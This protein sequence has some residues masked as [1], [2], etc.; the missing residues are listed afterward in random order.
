V[1]CPSNRATLLA[2]KAIIEAALT[3]L[4][5][6]YDELLDDNSESYSFD[7]G[8]GRQSTKRRTLE[9][10]EK[11]I[12]RQEIRLDNINDLLDC[13]GGVV[14]LGFNRLGGRF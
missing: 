2:R 7:D 3:K 5:A 12:N 4:Y 9:A 11:S 14:S 8:S 1:S 6:R 13:K 10:I